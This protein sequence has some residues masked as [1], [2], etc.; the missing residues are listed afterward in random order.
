[1]APELI[2]KLVIVGSP[3]P[4]PPASSSSS[5]PF[6]GEAVIMNKEQGLWRNL[7]VIGV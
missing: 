2:N 1:M 7:H 3:S 5:H 4:D 6:L